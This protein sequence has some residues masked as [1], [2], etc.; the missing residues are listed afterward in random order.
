MDD[1]SLSPRDSYFHICPIL[2]GAAIFVFPN[3]SVTKPLILL[4]SRARP[5]IQPDHLSLLINW[6][7]FLHQPIFSS[8]QR[9]QRNVCLEVSPPGGFLF[10]TVLNGTKASGPFLDGASI[11]HRATCP[12]CSAAVPLSHWD[13]AIE[14]T[15]EVVKG[16][17]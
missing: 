11:A 4:R 8:K 10:S 13:T 1:L 5:F 12:L 9:G 2:R 17:E 14:A 7:S 15:V 16:Q 6:Y 3:V